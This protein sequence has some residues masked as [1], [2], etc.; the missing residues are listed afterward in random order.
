MLSL[1]SLNGQSIE[2]G[3]SGGGI[4]V[5]G[6]LAGNMSMTVREVCQYWWQLEPS[7]DNKTD[8]SL[9]AVLPHNFFELVET[10]LKV[11]TPPNLDVDGLS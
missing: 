3:D 4:W 2:P 11:E 1:R 5:N 6:H 9:A 10:L 7:D 8:L